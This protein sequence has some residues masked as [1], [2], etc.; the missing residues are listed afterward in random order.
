ML[1]LICWYYTYLYRSAYTNFLEGIWISTDAF[2]KAANIR[3]IMLYINKHSYTWTQQ[4]IHDAYI[5]IMNDIYDGPLT[6][7]Y[8]LP[9]I[10]SGAPIF[11]ISAEFA[12]G[13]QIWGDATKAILDMSRG[14][15][16]IYDEDTVYAKLV[17]NHE[18]T[19]F[20]N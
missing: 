16:V 10:A 14:E 13:S 20:A 11:N 2:N 7:S 19:N 1:I 5:V 6:L 12:D 17:K 9:L 18:I 15:L 4:T 8:R 3:A